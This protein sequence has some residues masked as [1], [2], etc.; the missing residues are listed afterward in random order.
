LKK[1]NF[2]SWCGTVSFN[3]QEN[4]MKRFYVIAVAAA[5][6]AFL[7]NQSWSHGSQGGGG[8]GGAGGAGGAGGTG[9]AGSA[10]TAGTAG[11][12]GAG[13]NQVGTPGT[14]GAPGS[15]TAGAG[16]NANTQAGRAGANAQFNSNISQ[17]PFF[18]DPSVRSQLQLNNRQFNQLNT[19]YQRAFAN[20]NR[21]LTRLNTDTAAT[22]RQNTQLDTNR[23]AADAAA[24]RNAAAAARARATTGSNRATDAATQQRLAAMRELED[25]FRTDFDTAL[26]GTFTDAE[27]RQR[28]NQLNLQFQGIGAFDNP[29]VQ[30][31][32]NL[33]AQQR[34]QLAALQGEWR[35]EMMNLQRNRRGDLTQEQFNEL[36]MQFA[37]RLQGVLTPEQQQLWTE[38]LGQ[39]FDFPLTAFF[40]PTVG[41]PND[42]RG[43]RP[44]VPRSAT[45]T[46]QSPAVR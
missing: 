45:Q 17:T 16:I 35:R 3:W 19:A 32:M 1:S 14:A 9:A 4:I 18:A 29:V 12:A 27:M 39:P 36:R 11:T 28:F 30:Q 8:G 40:P 21:G 23:A 2:V 5:L 44:A 38:M 22:Q 20:Y 33:T 6:A 10:G 41:T 42:Q 13:A 25:R 37:N 7:S 26:D 34:Q 31:Q 15:A 24:R 43:A 46:P